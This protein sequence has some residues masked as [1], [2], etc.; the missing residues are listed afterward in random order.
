[1]RETAR[2]RM[3]RTCR[4]TVPAVFERDQ[5]AAGTRKLQR[6]YDVFQ[7]RCGH[8][9]DFFGHTHD[10]SVADSTYIHHRQKSR[11]RRAIWEGHY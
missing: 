8:E 1:M 2:I 10:C 3:P 6:L 11:L 9:V 7:P 5:D 4:V